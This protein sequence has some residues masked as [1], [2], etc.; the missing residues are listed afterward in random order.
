MAV[1]CSKGPTA[2]VTVARVRDIA[3]ISWVMDTRCLFAPR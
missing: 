3:W 1:G 2:E